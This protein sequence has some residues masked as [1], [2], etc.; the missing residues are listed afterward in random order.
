[1]IKILWVRIYL[2]FKTIFNNPA[3]IYLFKVSNI[4]T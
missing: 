3:N 4:N 2:N 1:M